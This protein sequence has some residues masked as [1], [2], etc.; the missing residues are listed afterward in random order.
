MVST[1]TAPSSGGSFGS[2]T[3]SPGDNAALAAALALK[4]D[5]AGGT[6]TGALVNSA[7]GAASTPPLLL[8]GNVFTGGSSTTTKPSL[9]VEPAGTTSNNWSTGG[10]GIGVNAPSGFLG[11][12]FNGQV[13]GVKMFGV[14]SAGNVLSRSGIFGAEFGLIFQSYGVN[15]IQT[16]PSIGVYAPQSTGFVAADGVG[17]YGFYN[18]GSGQVSNKILNGTSTPEGSKT[19]PPGSLALVN[20]AGTG[21]LWLKTSGTGNTGWTKVL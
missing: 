16:D 20:N 5:K 9:L 12:I 1:T 21:E 13:N 15:F 19:A 2:L 6:M 17:S 7:N 11:D 14:S 18:G 4:L 10:T 8:S 3:G